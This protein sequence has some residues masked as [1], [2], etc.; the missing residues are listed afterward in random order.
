MFGR[1]TTVKYRPVTRGGSRGS[2]EP[3]ILA[4]FYLTFYKLAK[5]TNVL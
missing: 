5:S 1:P 3:P 4:G 2:D